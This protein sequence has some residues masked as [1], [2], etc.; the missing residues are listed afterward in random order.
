MGGVDIGYPKKA[1]FVV[2]RI[3]NGDRGFI[4]NSPVIEI[5]DRAVAQVR[6]EKRWKWRVIQMAYLGRKGDV[7]IALS[8]HR[9]LETARQM[10]WAAKSAAGR[11]IMK[12]ETAQRVA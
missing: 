3:Q 12:I 10:L 7:E 6:I 8:L 11:H 9:P 2:D 1:A 4:E 5:T